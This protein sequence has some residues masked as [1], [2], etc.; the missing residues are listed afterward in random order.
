FDVALRRDEDDWL[1]VL[2]DEI[3]DQLHISSYYGHFFCHVL[4]QDHVAKKG[5]DPVALKKQMMELLEARGAAVPA[6]HNYGRLYHVPP[7]MEAH[8][9]ELD[10]CNVF[11]PGGGETSPRKNWAC[12]RRSASPRRRPRRCRRRERPDQSSSAMSAAEAIARRA[13]L[14]L[15]EREIDIT[16]MAAA[17]PTA[18]PM[19][20]E[21]ELVSPLRSLP[22]PTSMS[23]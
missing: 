1:E 2:P 22:R 16:T 10:P 7:E 19:A 5:V 21:K 18:A 11:N 23:G 8:F 15:R 12:A 9:K 13:C 3:A 14:L 17:N 4:H 20:I 6:E